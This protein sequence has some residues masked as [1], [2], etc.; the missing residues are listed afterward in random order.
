MN[1]LIERTCTIEMGHRLPDHKGKCRNIHGH[2]W[3]V[4]IAVSGRIKHEMGAPD[5][6]MIKDYDVLK[7]A[8]K[9]IDELFDHTLTLCS[10]DPL[11]E[12]LR[13]T[14]YG[15]ELTFP[16]GYQFQCAYGK[17][18]VL[19]NLPPTSENLAFVWSKVASNTLDFKPTDNAIFEGISVKETENSEAFYSLQ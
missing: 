3:K 12:L 18:N 5:D 11:V 1:R 19:Q 10:H 13:A 8:L 4:C 16:H 15:V 2:S 17:V 7:A 14:A 6:G 9:T